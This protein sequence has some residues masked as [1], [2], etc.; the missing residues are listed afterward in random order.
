M[1]RNFATSVSNIFERLQ[2]APQPGLPHFQTFAPSSFMI[3]QFH[4]EWASV[5]SRGLKHY[6][7]QESREEAEET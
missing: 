2:Q 5:T 4:R 3:S 1:H 6:S 7:A